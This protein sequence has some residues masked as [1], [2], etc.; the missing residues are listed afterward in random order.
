VWRRSKGDFWSSRFEP[1]IQELFSLVG[2]KIPER[3]SRKNLE[4]LWVS[5]NGR[6]NSVCLILPTT[7][8]KFDSVAECKKYYGVSSTN[9]SLVSR[10]QSRV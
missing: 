5:V 2:R 8:Y 10:T 3:G 9:T 6:P 1:L 7:R 4:V